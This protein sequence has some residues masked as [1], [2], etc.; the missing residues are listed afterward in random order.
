[1]SQKL[2][3]SFMRMISQWK[4]GLT[5]Q[6]GSLICLHYKCLPQCLTWL[7][8]LFITWIED[9]TQVLGL[10]LLMLYQQ[11]FSLPALAMHL[12]WI[13]SIKHLQQVWGPVTK[14]SPS[15]LFMLYLLGN[16]NKPQRIWQIVCRFQDGVLYCLVPTLAVCLLSLST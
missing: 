1:M 12:V 2:S 5:D 9:R 15:T 4:L 10:M 7:F 11:Q 14:L 16:E 8:Y 6:G 13:N 3:S